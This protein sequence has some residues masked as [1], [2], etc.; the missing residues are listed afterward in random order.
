MNLPIVIVGIYLI[1]FVVSF[2]L[3]CRELEQS[4]KD[5]FLRNTQSIPAA[6]I[7]IVIWP[8]AAILLLPDYIK[9]K[10][11]S[12]ELDYQ[13]AV[14]TVIASLKGRHAF[15]EG[16]HFFCK[17]CNYKI[18]IELDMMEGYIK[19]SPV[20]DARIDAVVELNRIIG[21]LKYG[22]Q[23]LDEK[24]INRYRNVFKI[25]TSEG[26]NIPTIQDLVPNKFEEF[27]N[28]AKRKNDSL[29]Q[30]VVSNAQEYIEPKDII[31][32]S[33]RVSKSKDVKSNIEKLADKNNFY[34]K[35]ILQI[36]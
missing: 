17:H 16:L 36:A 2:Y 9:E 14:D 4:H 21:S 29:R 33:K 3:Y 32:L 19:Y 1:G 27:I 18:K 23:R 15:Y 34:A 22:Y 26:L 28:M 6:M 12:H 8:V 13:R 24:L 7:A 31:Y 10:R 20:L 11:C 25:L 30:L 35:A 5:S